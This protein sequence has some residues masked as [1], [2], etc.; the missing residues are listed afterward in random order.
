MDVNVE[1]QDYNTWNTFPGS[2]ME[3]WECLDNNRISETI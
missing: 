3:K 1:F 2:A